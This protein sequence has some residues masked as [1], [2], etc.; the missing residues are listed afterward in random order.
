MLL[1]PGPVDVP[2]I[3]DELYM[4]EP[5][6]LAYDAAGYTLEAQQIE[7]D[8]GQQL[9]A[10]VPLL[11]YD[12]DA[13]LAQPLLEAS[14]ELETLSR[15][16]DT[17]LSP[18][19]VLNANL[20]DTYIQDAINA[21]PPEA[22][23][24]DRAPYQAPPEIPEPPPQEP[25]PV[26]PLP[27]EPPVITPYVPPVLQLSQKLENLTSFVDTIFHPGETFR[28]TITGPPYQA[29]SVQ[30]W[31][32]GA[33]LADVNYGQTGA[34]GTWQLIGYFSDGDKGAWV[35]QWFVGGATIN[36]PLFFVC[37]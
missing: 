28:L 12:P 5:S 15:L 21:T 8:T 32:N 31:L 30:T 16:A 10:F 23:A 3:P 35:E 6:T 29:V 34:D 11:D 24:A 36:P 9:L 17:D 19:W 27:Y 18:D 20:G 14:P 7:D 22:I 13:D 26:A 1:E 2:E 37:V 25:E 33:R 4:L